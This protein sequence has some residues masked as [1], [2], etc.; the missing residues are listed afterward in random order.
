MHLDTNFPPSFFP[1]LYLQILYPKKEVGKWNH[2]W[3]THSCSWGWMCAVGIFYQACMNVY[4][5]EE[6]IS[7]SPLLQ[8]FFFS[9]YSTLA[10]TQSY[11]LYFRVSIQYCLPGQFS[12]HQPFH[13]RLWVCFIFISI[14]IL[15]NFFMHICNYTKHVCFCKQA[16]TRVNLKLVEEEEKSHFTLQFYYKLVR[17]RRSVSKVKFWWWGRFGKGK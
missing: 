8:Y 3:M 14:K 16:R 9:F 15:L 6:H 13:L 10:F 7:F 12:N 5:P 4:F 1:P 17:W 2:T 11:I